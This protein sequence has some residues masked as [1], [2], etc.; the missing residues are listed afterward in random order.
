LPEASGLWL[1]TQAPATTADHD[2]ELRSFAGGSEGAATRGVH[3]ALNA[4]QASRS[5]DTPYGD[6]D[7]VL[8]LVSEIENPAVVP[9]G[10]FP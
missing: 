5:M 1:R 10:H 7:K 8:A 2:A 9:H 3:F 4:D 6:G